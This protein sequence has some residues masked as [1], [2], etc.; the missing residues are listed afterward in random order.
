MSGAGRQPW[1]SFAPAVGVTHP[2][3]VR[4]TDHD[5]ASNELAVSIAAHGLQHSFVAG[6]DKRVKYAGG[7]GQRRLLALKSA[8][9]FGV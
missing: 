5:K 9:S 4:K 6:K 8:T 1:L 2:G 3:N 7:G